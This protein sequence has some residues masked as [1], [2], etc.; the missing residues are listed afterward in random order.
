MNAGFAV[1]AGLTA[2]TWAIHTFVGGPEVATPLLASELNPVP[3]YTAYYC[4]HIVTLV[5]AAMALAFAY[6]AVVPNEVGIAVMSTA[7]SVAFAAWSVGLVLS[8]RRRFYELPQ[9]T[10]F[11]LIAGA[12]G[13]G[14]FA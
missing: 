3:R 14:L 11:V 8:A 4:W 12:G 2:V 13:V 5:L 6:A 1:A 9:W 7:L 10:F